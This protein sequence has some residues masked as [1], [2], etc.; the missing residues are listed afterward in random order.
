MNHR[1]GL[2]GTVLNN[3]IVIPVNYGDCS[4]LL[5]VVHIVFLAGCSDANTMDQR[6]KV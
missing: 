6:E 5:V 4:F 3:Q 2:V 1:Q